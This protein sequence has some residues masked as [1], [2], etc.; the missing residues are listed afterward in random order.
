MVEE[1]GKAIAKG[2]ESTETESA[3]KAEQC[4]VPVA[5]ALKVTENDLKSAVEGS[6]KTWQAMY[7]EALDWVQNDAEHFAGGSDDEGA[8]G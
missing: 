8:W 1:I 3:I 5:A 2:S 6:K 4:W 7:D